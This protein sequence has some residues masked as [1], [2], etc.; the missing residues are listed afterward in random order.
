LL[1]RRRLRR[2]L[3]DLWLLLL[4]FFITFPAT[5]G[6]LLSTADVVR[7]LLKKGGRNTVGQPWST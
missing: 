3:T 7:A 5:T 6:M 2:Q 4:P 1:R